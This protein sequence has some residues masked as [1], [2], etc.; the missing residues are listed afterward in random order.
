LKPVILI[1]GNF[2][3]ENRWPLIALLLYVFVFGGA[4]ASV[5]EASAE[6]ILFF[7]RSVAMYGLAF[8]GLLAASAIN[9][10]RRSR[11]ILAVLSKAVERGQY[12]V[13]LLAGVML[14]AAIYCAAIGIVGSAALARHGEGAGEVW[15]L[16]AILLAGFLLV[17]TAAL[18]F[19][20][21]LHPLLAAAAAAATLAATAAAAR[22]LGPG[23]ENLLPA[24]TLVSSMVSF[25]VT[26]WQPPW[27]AAAAAVVHA[28]VFW[29]LATVV[30]SRRDIAV[31]VE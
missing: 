17:A 27:L 25:T 31:A 10:E 26:G 18:F 12:L 21:F 28:A 4:M 13:G 16:V 7:L 1:A 20:T 24:Y 5:G 15:G 14:A 2:V 11:R 22:A 3:R 30:F 8:T 9:N 29:A 6:D 23:W 19:S